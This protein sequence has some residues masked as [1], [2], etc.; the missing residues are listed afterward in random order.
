M[1]R[2]VFPSSLG[3]YAAFSISSLSL[4]VW[5]YASL[6]F[7]N[8]D[9]DPLPLSNIVTAEPAVQLLIIYGSFILWGVVSYSALSKTEVRSKLQLMTQ[10]EILQRG[11]GL[12][13]GLV[14]VF[15]FTLFYWHL[16]INLEFGLQN[17]GKGSFSSW[18]WGMT[19]LIG[20]VMLFQVRAFF[21]ESDDDENVIK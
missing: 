14:A 11:L 3:S 17:L 20:F 15:V 1:G 2:F 4:I 13:L 6:G 7:A 21:W 18:L 19:A 10:R 12:L 8:M 9:G 16:F 5:G